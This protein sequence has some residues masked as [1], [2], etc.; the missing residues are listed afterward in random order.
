MKFTRRSLATAYVVMV[1]RVIG[2]SVIRVLQGGFVVGRRLLVSSLLLPLFVFPSFV[3]RLWALTS[4]EPDVVD[5]SYAETLAV[6]V[7]VGLTG[8]GL[9]VMVFVISVCWLGDERI[10]LLYAPWRSP[11]YLNLPRFL[12]HGVMA[13]SAVRGRGATCQRTRMG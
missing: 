11:R 8:V 1:V 4:A 5:Q 6:S 12:G 9:F 3:L 7:L 10:W 2:V 13:D